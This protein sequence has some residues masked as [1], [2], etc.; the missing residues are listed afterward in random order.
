M[1]VPA[2]A[3]GTARLGGRSILVVGAAGGIGESVVWALVAQGAQVVLSDLPQRQGQLQEL[4]GA[5]EGSGGVA[6]WLAVDASDVADIRRAVDQAADLFGGLD[7][8]VNCTGTIVRKPSVDLEPEEWDRVVDVN[9]K[10]AFFLAQ[11]AARLMIPRGRGKVIS[12]AS[13]FGLVGSVE[14]AAYAASKGGLVNLTRAL[15]VEW[16]PHNIQVNA[17]APTFVATPL[18]ASYF[19]R[20]GRLKE[21][22]RQTPAGRL[23]RPEEVAAAAVY[24]AGPDA[25][26]VT[27][28][29]L[30][31]DGGWTAV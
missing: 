24:L 22:L 21:V 27:G 10:G 18:T 6:R 16:A 11:A 28:V 30:P 1:V 29:T 12:L 14:R 5:I 20:R 17:I 8:L 31:V 23:A 26:M 2:S 25:D 15:A 3:Q 9:L 13:T 19:R 4:V 7:V